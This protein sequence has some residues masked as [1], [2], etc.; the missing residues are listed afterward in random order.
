MK[1]WSL[2]FCKCRCASQRRIDMPMKIFFSFTALYW[3][4]LWHCRI[5]HTWALNFISPTKLT[6]NCCSSVKIVVY[7]CHKHPFIPSNPAFLYSHHSRFSFSLNILKSSSDL[8]LF[9]FWLFYDQDCSQN[10]YKSSLTHLWS[11]LE[12]GT[13]WKDL[14]VSLRIANRYFSLI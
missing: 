2:R 9:I 11:S 13:E 1:H 12:Y 8:V 7:I 5:H 4:L 10:R 6:K 14:E 3:F